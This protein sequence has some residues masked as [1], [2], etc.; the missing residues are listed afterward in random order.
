MTIYPDKE[1][2]LEEI[3]EH[4]LAAEDAYVTAEIN[5]DET[6]LNLLVDERF[7]LNAS[8]GTAADKRELIA[9]VLKMQMTHQN[10][11]PRSVMIEGD[12]AI[13][14]RTTDLKFQKTN[15]QDRLSK[16][17]LISVY[18]NRSGQWRL[19]AF[20]MQTPIE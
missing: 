7:V 10:I 11:S 14:F 3:K 5:R 15:E 2:A 18:M 17:R 1:T 20:Q 16:F 12:L 9:V 4:V 8:D 13:I 6:A 19:L